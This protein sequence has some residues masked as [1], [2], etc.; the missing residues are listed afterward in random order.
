MRG[1]KNWYRC[2]SRDEMIDL[3]LNGFDYKNCRPE[4][5][6]NGNTTYYFIRTEELENYMASTVKV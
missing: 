5:Y 4:K 1:E 2:T 6:N 3:V